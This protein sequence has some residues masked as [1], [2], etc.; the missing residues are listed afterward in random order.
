MKPKSAPHQAALRARRKAEGLKTLIRYVKPEW[1]P[2]I[3]KLIKELE[4]QNV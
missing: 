2:E 3:D 4:K 1:I